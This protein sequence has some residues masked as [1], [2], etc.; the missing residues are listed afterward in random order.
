MAHADLDAAGLP[1]DHFG[2][3]K[4]GDGALAVVEDDVLAG[5]EDVGQ[6]RR[7][8]LGPTA[9]RRHEGKLQRIAVVVDLEHAGHLRIPGSGA[10]YLPRY[11]DTRAPHQIE[12]GKAGLVR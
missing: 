6:Q 7:H 2:R 8:V 4:G 11:P 12:E 10:R 9:A 3:A 5:F 1:V